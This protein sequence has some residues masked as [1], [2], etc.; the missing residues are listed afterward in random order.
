MGA[1]MSENSAT[2]CTSH[3]RSPM[4]QMKI[5]AGNGVAVGNNRN[6]A[7]WCVGYFFHPCSRVTLALLR[8][9]HLGGGTSEIFRS[10]H[11]A[12][13]RVFSRLNVILEDYL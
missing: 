3:A 4:G 9:C 12:V 7:I 6:Y 2:G 1:R 11:I 8:Y 10:K 13:C 5:F